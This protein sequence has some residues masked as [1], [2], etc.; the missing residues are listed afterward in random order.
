MKPTRIVLLAALAAALFAPLFYCSNFQIYF[1]LQ[2]GGLLIS[3]ALL[4]MQIF[5]STGK[6]R[7]IWL[8]GVLIYPIILFVTNPVFIG[9]SCQSFISEHEVELNSINIAVQSSPVLMNASASQVSAYADFPEE[10]KVELK[11]LCG[12][13]NLEVS[14]DQQYVMFGLRSGEIMGFCPVRFYKPCSAEIADFGLTPINGDWY[15]Q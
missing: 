7:L 1:L 8:A 12:S 6:A 15:Y 11:R 14:G 10:K 2:W 3:A 5:R 13:L 4:L 9:M